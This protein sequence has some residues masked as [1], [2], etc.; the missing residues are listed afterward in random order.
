ML[1]PDQS[2]RGLVVVGG[3][4][5]KVRPSALSVSVRTEPFH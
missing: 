2:R 4:H 3:A 1:G 5:R